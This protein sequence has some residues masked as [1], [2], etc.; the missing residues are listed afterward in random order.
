[1]K[2]SLS[3]L[4]LCLHM[5]F[6]QTCLANV[7]TSSEQL[8]ELQLAEVAGYIERV[9]S[10]RGE[11][12]MTTADL[13]TGSGTVSYTLYAVVEAKILE[14]DEQLH[15]RTGRKLEAANALSKLIR[16]LAALSPESEVLLEDMWHN[17]KSRRVRNRAKSLVL[18]RLGWYQRRNEIMQN[19][20]SYQPGQALMT[21]RYLNLLAHDDITY[22]RWAAEEIAR[23]DGAETAVYDEM[24]NILKSRPRVKL[25]KL[26][27]D[28]YSWY[29]KTLR[30]YGE[31]DYSDVLAEIAAAPDTESKMQ[32]H[33]KP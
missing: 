10:Q 16:S 28:T 11:A 24:A 17:S 20:D 1:M 4:V 22:G 2:I 3:M 12:L 7:A 31:G 30:K 23:R 21:H 14:L 27:M 9:N 18:Q 6:A 13:I 33:C 8:K 5:M 26:A 29:C 19:A 32:R 25:E 15:E